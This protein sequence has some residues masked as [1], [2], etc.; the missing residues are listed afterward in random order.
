VLSDECETRGRVERS[1]NPNGG[2]HR[3]GRSHESIPDESNRHAIILA[4]GDGPR[5]SEVTRRITGDAAPKQFYPVI[6]DTSL[7]EQ[8]RLRV[9]LVLGENRILT[10]LN[11]AHERHYRDFAQ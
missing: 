7:L 9:S 1:R 3:Q 4:G 10:V 8:T 11:R 2:R 5:P 6:G